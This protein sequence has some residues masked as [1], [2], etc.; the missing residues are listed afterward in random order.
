MHI[1][2]YSQILTPLYLMTQKKDFKCD[3][4]K[5][6]FEHTEQEIVHAVALGPVRT[7]QD[8]KNMLYHCS[9]GDESFLDPL[10]ECT[11]RDFR[12]TSGV[13]ELGQACI[14]NQNFPGILEMITNC[15]EVFNTDDGLWGSQCPEIKEH[16]CEND[17]VPVI[18]ELVQD[19]LLLLDPYKSMGSDGI[20][21]KVLKELT[22]VI[23]RPLSM[24]FEW[25]WESGEVQVY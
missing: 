3:L 12:M 23:V 4:K 20:N 17:Q 19:V 16:G 6:V 22:D 10:T 9:W 7:G 1:P 15:P 2:E 14:G 18:P 25:S 11:C 21:P 8:V 5:Q 24:N 13:P